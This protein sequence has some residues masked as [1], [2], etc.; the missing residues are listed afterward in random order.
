MSAPMTYFSNR[1][2]ANAI[3]PNA[4]NFT[5]CNSTFNAYEGDINYIL[6][7]DEEKKLQE[8]LSAPNSS[9]NYTT[10]LNKRTP[11]TGVW[12][13]D[14]PI[15]NAWREEHGILWIQGKGFLVSSW[16]RKDSST[17]HHN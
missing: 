9:I 16:I 8:W 1:Q 5:V 4:H 12:I 2:S 17:F 15:Y 14:H 11:G 7:N 10:A 6:P 13:F 3:F